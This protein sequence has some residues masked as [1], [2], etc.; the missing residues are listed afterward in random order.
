MHTYRSIRIYLE[1]AAA[2]RKAIKNLALCITNDG[3]TTPSAPETKEEDSAQQ[4]VNN[5]RRKGAY[6][7]KTEPTLMVCAPWRRWRHSC[8]NTG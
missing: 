3:S 4:E 1:K 5:T 2:Q 8:A 7:S 6:K